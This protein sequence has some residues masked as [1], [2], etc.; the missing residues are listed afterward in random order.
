M[1]DD[2]LRKL[3][4]ARCPGSQIYPAGSRTGEEP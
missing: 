1:P 3:R 4:F 2:P